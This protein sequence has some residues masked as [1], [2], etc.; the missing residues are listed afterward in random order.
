[1]KVLLHTLGWAGLLTIAPAVLN[2]SP[3]RAD[4]PPSTPESSEAQPQLAGQS[5]VSEQAVDLELS[6]ELLPVEGEALPPALVADEEQHRTV[7]ET[8]EIRLNGDE[9]TANLAGEAEDSAAD[10]VSSDEIADDRDTVQAEASETAADDAETSDTANQPGGDETTA[11]DLQMEL[12]PAES[13]MVPA[14][15]RST[16]AL[17]GAITDGAGNPLDYDVVVTLTTTAGQFVETDYDRDRSGFQVLA[18]R[19]QFQVTLQAGL[20]AQAVEIRAWADGD[21]ARNQESTLTADPPPDLEATTAVNFVTHLRPSLVSGYVDFRVGAGGTDFWGSFSE[22]LNPDLIGRTEWDLDAGLFATGTFGEWQFTGALNTERALNQTCEG[23]RLFRDTQFCDQAY[24]VYG[25]SSQVDYLTPSIDNFYLRFQRDSEVPGAEPDYFMW[26]DYNTP[27][28]ARPSQQFTAITRQLHGFKGNY[29]F[30]N[31]QV[32]AMYA[33]NLRPFQRDTLVPDGTSGFYFL[34]R[35]S[36]LPG[37]EDIF[38]EVEELNRPGTVLSREPL[39]RGADYEIDYDR[40]T[41][42]FRQPILA[43]EAD[44]FG[45][46]LVRRIVATYQVDGVGVG[47]NLYA[48]R[49][50]YNLEPGTDTAG[51]AGFS[52]LLEDQ[53]IQQFRLAGVDAQIPLGEN[54]RLTAELATSSLNATGQTVSGSAYRFEALGTILP[55]IVGSAYLSSA[56]SGFSNTATSSFRP[57]QT[58]YGASL[59]ANFSPTTQVTVQFDREEN[60]GVAPQV[61]TN[62]ADLLIPGQYTTPGSAVDNTLTTFQIGVEQR[63][64]DATVGLGFVNRSRRDR[65]LGID[66]NA[67]QLVPSLRVPLAPTLEFLAQS[68]LNFGSDVD[69]LYPT[70][71]SLGLEWDVEPGVSLRLTQQFISGGLQPSSVTSLDTIADYALGDNTSLTSRYSLISGYGGLIGQSA[72]GLNHRIVLAPGLRV[73]LGFERIINDAFTTTGAGQQFAQPFAVGNLGA[74]ALGLQSGT[75]YSVGLEY[76]D[77]PNFQASARIEH[78]DSLAG[79]NTVLSAAAAG[80]V[81]PSLTTLFRYQQANYANQTITGRLGNSSSLKLGLA[82]RNPSNDIFNGLLSYEY[83]RNPSTTP[84]SLLIDSAIGSTDHTFAFEGIYAPNWQWEFYTKYAFRVNNATLAEDFSTSSTIQ[85]AQFRA[86]YRFAYRW[87][88]LGEVRWITQPSAGYSETGLALELGYY[89]S[90]DLRLGLGYSFGSVN[91]DGFGG[92]GY[93]SAGGVYFGVQIKVNE[94]L[95]DFGLQTVTPAQQSESYVDPVTDFPAPDVDFP[96]PLP[97]TQPATPPPAPESVEPPPAPEPVE[98]SPVDAPATPT[99][100]PAEDGLIEPL[101]TES[102]VTR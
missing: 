42:I 3:A 61:S 48:A 63:F 10:G 37:S 4:T 98:P 17:A 33:N 58:R 20:T 22:F 93:R 12:A 23:N 81:S 57:G 30:G 67:Q 62:A 64:G 51:W 28:F 52:V 43:T 44:V 54:G 71:T 73:N 19:G 102:E 39:T 15:G 41:L 72:L 18:R 50:Q 35:R 45:E 99:A 11:A 65:I 85:L 83:R 8:V 1:M 6:S 26:G 14:D 16:V 87:D 95:N 92:S 96:E 40:G 88:V 59:T 13:P 79:D 60:V 7:L 82:Y 84:T 100:P 34:S 80:R 55:G 89:L 77:N 78:R 53:G 66:T 36:I 24:P 86:T 29:T 56:S 70:R 68:E 2:P 101:P 97:P 27:E 32:T 76:T 46:M 74:T 91:S 38:I 21:A 5:G 69:A 49:L 9:S 31:F 75:S 90:P 47:G 25:D 94:L